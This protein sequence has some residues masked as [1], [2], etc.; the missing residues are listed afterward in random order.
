MGNFLTNSWH[1]NQIRFAL[2]VGGLFTF[3]GIV[4]F[5]VWMFGDT[6]GYGTTQK[7]VIIALVLLTLPFVLIIGFVSSRRQKK[8][9]AALEAEKS[10][11]EAAPVEQKAV[12]APESEDFIKGAEEVAQ[13]L[14]NSDLAAGGKDAIYSLPWYLTMGTPKSGKSSLVLGSNLNF[15]TLPSQRASEQK[16]IR[17]TRTVDWRVTSDAVFLD[18]AGRF[19]TEGEDAEEWNSLLDT[20]KKYRANRPLDG[21]ILSV[22][23][24]RILHADER[25][26]EEQ[27]KVLR[28]RLDEARQ[29]LKV[30]FPVYLVF[31]HADAIEGFRDSFS[32]S[33]QEG[34]NLVWGATIPL[35]KSDTAAS[36][37]DGEYEILQDSIMKRR[38]LRLSAPFPPVR[39][40]RIFNFPLHFGSARRK[41]GAFVTTLFRPNPFSESPFLRG[42]YFTA[43]PINRPPMRGNQTLA[44]AAIQQT[45]GESF[46]TQRLFRDVILRDK[47]LVKTFQD[48]QQKPPIWGW[49]LTGLGAA[50]V[51]FLLAMS[52]YSLLANKKLVDEASEK[53]EAVLTIYKA[54]FGKNPL[55]KKPEEARVEISALDRLRD[56]LVV[57]DNYDREGAPLGLRF[58]MYSGNRIYEDRLLPIY[59]QAVEQRFKKP[60]VAKL[61]D[62]LKK[63]AASP[64]SGNA[65]QQ[66][67]T[68]GKNYDLLKTYL[69]L[70]GDYRE[71]A[72]T[73]TLS[74]NLKDYWKTESKLPEDLILTAQEQLDFYAKQVDRSEFPRIK[75][76][77]KI[78]ADARRKLQS[79][80]AVSRY[81]RRKVTEISKEVEDKIGTMSAERILASNGGD[82][83]FI[84]GSHI[85]PGAYTL[86]GFQLMKTAIS[87]AN[88]KLSEDDWVMGEQGKKEIAQTTDSGKLQEFYYRDY[89]DQWKQFV[90]SLSI[91]PY[92]KET[93]DNALQSFS[94]ANSP[95][96]ILLKEIERN[97]NLSGKPKKMGW[98]WEWV[99]SWFSS[100]KPNNT[101]GNT[102]V[103]KEFRPLFT[104]V[105]D[106]AQTDTPLGKYRGS[107]GKVANKFGGFSPNEIETISQELAKDNDKSFTEL[108]KAD[109]DIKNLLGVFSDTPSGQ[110]LAD[111]LRQPLDN[112]KTIFGADARSQL[113]KTWTDSLLPKAKEIEKGY[114]FSGEGVADLAKVSA[115]LNPANGELTRFYNERLKIYFEE[116]DGEL[117]VKETSAVKFS[118]EFVAYLNNAFKLRRALFGE[119][120]PTPKF[121]YEFRLQ[122]VKDAL[123]E[124][125]IDGQKITS[126]GTGSSKMTFPA[127][128]G[129]ET[130]V[131]MKFASTAAGATSGTTFSTA[132][133][134]NSNSAV[135]PAPKPDN[136]VSSG[137]VSLSFP[138][139]WGLFKFVDA[140]GS[141]S[142]QKQASGEYN[143]NY[144]LRGKSVAAT[145]RPAGED[146]FNKE[147]FRKVSAPQTLLKP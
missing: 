120:S 35:E 111:F 32:T 98:N 71:R 102:Q 135:P 31:T 50:L 49:L 37:F 46:F 139:S 82:T 128:S 67:E 122:P 81:Y 129:A 63:F 9:A 117:R 124:V 141:G 60:V 109:G 65:E 26:I 47:D 101:G 16:F 24:E 99:K 114:P 88:A 74:N 97:T 66:E 100:A 29:R 22:S 140:G 106:E 13:F 86:E 2:G 61:E 75:L 54:D 57:L 84:E 87:E 8:K 93:A 56:Q 52:A 15:Q 36:L 133:A 94:S 21:L 27:A 39:Q 132:P 147:I 143:L 85:V 64:L 78:V 110:E 68:L 136:A 40:L 38:L 105:G 103:E 90:K 146:L 123:I 108:R 48:Q 76:D 70:S 51:L 73:A 80:P 145:V 6:F 10:A 45:V 115:F 59:V 69:M 72:D 130:G 79:Y 1:F 58:G 89:A 116:K 92:T 44:N 96:E 5:F 3:Y 23:A 43:V 138:G 53:G 18:T 104:F 107:L 118:D 119:S 137:D 19:Q 91:K 113:A 12:A 62:D 17:P 42:F 127:S 28:N 95:I 7:I 126:E 34:K 20:I 25:E 30:R 4:G 131:L 134:G 14:K 11:G 125:T 112:L 33:K 55:D 121:E 83:N 41:L 144:N 77:E 142:P